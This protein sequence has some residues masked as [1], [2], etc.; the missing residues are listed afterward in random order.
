MNTSIDFNANGD[1]IHVFIPAKFAQR[2]GRKKILSPNGMPVNQDRNV[3]AD[4]TLVGALIRAHRWKSWLADKTYV[5]L[6]EVAEAEHISSSSYASRIF[7][8]ILLAPDIQADI[9][10]GIHP[11][12]LT[13]ADFMK[14][15]PNDWV[16]Q[17]VY[18]GVVATFSQTH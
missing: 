5:R 14:A 18:F 3:G 9:L 2:A 13:L 1:M 6:S 12:H 11:A 16:E 17:R 15:F 10:D 8:L 7:R 4:A